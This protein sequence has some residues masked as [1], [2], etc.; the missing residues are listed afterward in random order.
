[1]L[2]APKPAQAN[3]YDRC[4][5]SLIDAGIGLEVATASCAEALHPERVSSCVVDIVAKTAVDPSQALGACSRDRRPDDLAT[6]V[7]TIYS[8]LADTSAADALNNCRRSI[9]PV[10]YSDCVIGVAGAAEISPSESMAICTVAGY[11]PEN[12]APTFIYSR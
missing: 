7:N 8:T 10:R 1:M 3:P 11:R 4:T 2:A 6:C 9:L 12:V 5:A